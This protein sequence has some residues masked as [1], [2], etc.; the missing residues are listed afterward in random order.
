MLGVLTD[1]DN[2]LQV[3]M[4]DP[5]TGDLRDLGYNVFA[6]NK[7][8]PPGTFAKEDTAKAQTAIEGKGFD[9][10]LTVVLVD[11]TKDRY[12]VSGKVTEYNTYYDRFGRYDRYYT[13][14]S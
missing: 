8:F 11:K 3:K 7:I 12:Y 2:E 10:I 14:V 1:N 4:E 6:A 5:L 9:G 13:I